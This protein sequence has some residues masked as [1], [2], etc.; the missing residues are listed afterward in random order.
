VL[1]T[2]AVLSV[3]VGPFWEFRLNDADVSAAVRATLTEP[4]RAAGPFGESNFFALSLAMLVPVALH[5]MA[6]GGL[7][8]LLGLT[9][10]VAVVGGIF[11]A[12]SRGGLLAA[13]VG[14]AAAL[15]W[16]VSAR[17]LLPRLG[18]LAV[19]VA[20]VALVLGPTFAQ[21]TAGAGERTVGG[22]I[23]ENT[24]ALAVWADHP[25]T[26][27]GPGGYPLA[28]RDYARGIGDDPRILREPHSLVL[29]LLSEQG[30]AGLLAWLTAAGLLVAW[31]RRSGVLRTAAGRTLA[32]G[33]LVYLAGTVF[34]HDSQQ[35]LL[36]LLVGM[37]VG[38]GAARPAPGRER[39]P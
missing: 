12:G 11:A 20:L 22:R 33:I 9:T 25:L 29:Q 24:I 2:G 34:L 26:G 6:R 17:Q 7:G 3:L 23:T 8:R 4:P 28:Y 15:S 16:G 10:L 35:R 13:A 36:F 31:T 18:L 14:F 1:G 32:L 5:V 21:Q 38:L 30:T 27:L 37:L 19:V 39:R